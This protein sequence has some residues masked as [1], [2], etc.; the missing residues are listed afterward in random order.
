MYLTHWRQRLRLT[1]V[2]CLL[3]STAGDQQ[4]YLMWP[5]S[6]LILNSS[7]RC[8]HICSCWLCWP[9]VLGIISTLLHLSVKRYTPK[10]VSSFLLIMSG[11]KEL[12]S[13]YTCQLAVYSP[14]DL[15][16]MNELLIH[17]CQVSRDW[18]YTHSVWFTTFHQLPVLVCMTLLTVISGVQGQC[19]LQQVPQFWSSC[20]S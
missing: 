6:L 11:V 14:S 15:F 4:F 13:L 5:K 12:Y 19:V 1:N 18:R 17:L 8:K 2:T 7:L 3:N 9:A 10:S 16:I 20:S